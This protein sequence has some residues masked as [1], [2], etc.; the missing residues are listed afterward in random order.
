MLPIEEFLDGKTL[1]RQG[2][3]GTFKLESHQAI[4][5]YPHISTKLWHA[6]DEVGKQTQEYRDIKNQLG[7]DWETDLTDNFE[8]QIEAAIL[9]GYFDS[10]AEQEV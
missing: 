4:Y 9:L 8:A 10:P 3:S 6:P 1:V 5:P 2:I 7:D